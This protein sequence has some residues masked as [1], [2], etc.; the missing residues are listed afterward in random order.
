MTGHLLCV[1]LEPLSYS[2]PMCGRYVQ[3]KAAGQLSVDLRADFGDGLQETISWNIAPTAPVPIVVDRP[4]GERAHRELHTARW[5]LLPIWAKDKAQSARAFNARSE[6]VADKPTFRSA[7]RSRRCA[8]PADAYYEWHASGGTKQPYAVRRADGASHLFAGLYEW[9]RPQDAGP[10]EPWV[11]SCTILTGPS[12]DH[13]HDGVLGELAGLHD[14]MPLPLADATLEEW[15]APGKL[16][17]PDA[18]HLVSRVRSEALHVAS[19][20]EVSPVGRAVGNVRNDGPELLD[21]VSV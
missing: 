8:V 15:L 5:G 13:G 20:W 16:T 7:V 12:P 4:H 3:S 14:R 11:L 17:K 18:E 9:W 10:Q 6:T 19:A 1:C 21:P 2:G